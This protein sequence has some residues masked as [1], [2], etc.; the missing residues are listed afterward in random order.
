MSKMIQLVEEMRA[1]LNEVADTEQGLVRA[2]GDALTG[3]DQTILQNVRSITM[4]HESRRSMILHELQSLATR[5]GAFPAAREPVAGLEY[6]TPVS[7]IA[8]ASAN[9]N[10]HF[11]HVG[12]WRKA[13]SN[14]EDEL[15]QF[16][17]VRTSAL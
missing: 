17:Q 5:I 10:D 7:A 14:I 9:A 12:D 15:D 1:R 3:G 2:L 8:S 6:T 13:A 11:F 4:E 16:C